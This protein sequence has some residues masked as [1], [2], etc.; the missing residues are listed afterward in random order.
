MP[1]TFYVMDA[2]TA[3]VGHEDCYT[4]SEV[5]AVSDALDLE[6]GLECS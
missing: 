2:E 4:T 5:C 1:A 6:P 3:I